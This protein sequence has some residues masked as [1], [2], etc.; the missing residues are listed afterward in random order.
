MNPNRVPTSQPRGG[1]NDAA[2]FY[3]AC[4]EFV[5]D[6]LIKRRV[7][8]QAVEIILG[9]P[10]VRAFDA[11]L[12]LSIGQAGQKEIGPVDLVVLEACTGF[13]HQSGLP[14]EQV[15]APAAAEGDAGSGRSFGVAV[16]E[17]ESVMR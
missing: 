13:E 1:P 17:E 9:L 12:E 7:R 10:S 15:V 6:A 11:E 8:S 2:S 14:L 3:P 4:L 16:R 5:A